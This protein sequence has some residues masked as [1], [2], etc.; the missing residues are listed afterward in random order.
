MK[1]VRGVYLDLPESEYF[2]F[3]SGYK[4]YFSSEFNKRR[5]IEQYPDYQLKMYDK[6]KRSLNIDP[7]VIKDIDQI[8]LFTFY[9]HIEKRGF[10]I[11]Y[12]DGKGGLTEWQANP[13]KHTNQDKPQL[14]N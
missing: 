4:F 13:L 2:V 7:M 8:L 12:N 6:V 10:Y 5:F 1:T 3:Y 9:E 11:V 14:E